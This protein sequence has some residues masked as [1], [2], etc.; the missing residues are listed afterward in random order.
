[1]RNISHSL[2]LTVV[3]TVFVIMPAPAFDGE[4]WL[5][6]DRGE[7]GENAEQLWVGPEPNANQLGKTAVAKLFQ[8]AN[9]GDDYRTYVLDG[10]QAVKE[11]P[12]AVVETLFTPDTKSFLNACVD[13]PKVSPKYYGALGSVMDIAMDASTRKKVWA[14]IKQSVD[15]A[16]PTDAAAAIEA[17]ATDAHM[18]LK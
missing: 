18:D 1:M 13:D 9:P 3:Y 5:I 10:K 15:M 16:I 11:Q 4:Q 12:K 2:Y 14:Q 17:H 6:F 8:P 7:N